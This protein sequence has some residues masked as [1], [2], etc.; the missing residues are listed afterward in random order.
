MHRHRAH[1]AALATG[2]AVLLGT[3]ALVAPGLAAAQAPQP[4]A[5]T[6]GPAPDA[7]APPAAVPSTPAAVNPDAGQTGVVQRILVKGNER[8]EPATVISY[9]PIAPGERIDPSKIDLA[10]KTLFRTD[11]FSDVKI[12]FV[13]GDLIITIVLC[14]M[15]GIYV[16][17][18]NAQV[19]HE[20]LTARGDGMPSSACQVSKSECQ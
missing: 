9:L 7:A 13:A 20:Q 12:D 18:R 17:Y 11:L 19:V 5:P 3:T 2:F 16:Q 15:W 1:S 4:T 6:R 10:L 8:I 14:G